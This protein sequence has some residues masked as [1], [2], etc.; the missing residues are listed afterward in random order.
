MNL[1]FFLVFLVLLGLLNSM[2]MGSPISN[3]QCPNHC[4]CGV[5]NDEELI[6]CT[7]GESS[8]TIK[9]SQ[10]TYDSGALFESDAEGK[11]LTI[12]CTTFDQFVYEIAPQLNVSNLIGLDYSNCPLPAKQSLSLG[13]LNLYGIQF[14]TDIK[15]PLS[16]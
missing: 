2:T 16:I 8:F 5:K 10:S 11:K 3:G 14:T 9:V 1:K 15:R 12:N 4:E 6:A 13:F 7:N